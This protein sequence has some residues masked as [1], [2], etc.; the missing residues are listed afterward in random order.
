MVEVD[1]VI[2]ALFVGLGHHLARLGDVVGDRLLAQ[3]VEPGLQALHGRREVVA[4]VL[5]AG[6][7][8]AHGIQLLV[9]QQILHAV[10]GAHAVLGRGLV[11][12]LGDDIADGDQFAER[13]CLVDRGVGIADIA[14]ADD[15]DFQHDAISLRV[16]YRCYDVVMLRQ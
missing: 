8:D 2:D 9:A 16:V 1:A 11:G 3:D 12:A 13:I 14:H 6:R 5:H 7:T 4:A 15:G 10:V